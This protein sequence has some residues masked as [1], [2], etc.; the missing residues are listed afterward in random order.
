MFR[1]YWRVSICPWD[2]L[3]NGDAAGNWL[4]QYDIRTPHQIEL[5]N[6]LPVSGFA[7]ASISF[8]LL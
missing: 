4:Q 1:G 8:D 3:V 2:N 6:T 7:R 5:R